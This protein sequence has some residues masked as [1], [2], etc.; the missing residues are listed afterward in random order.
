M[1]TEKEDNKI[2][3]QSF[4]CIM[5]TSC[6]LDSFYFHCSFHLSIPHLLVICLCTKKKKNAA[7]NSELTKLQYVEVFY[8]PLL[9]NA[10]RPV[11]TE[12]LFIGAPHQHPTHTA[13][14]DWQPGTVNH[15]LKVGVFI[16]A[17]LEKLKKKKSSVKLQKQIA[18]C[19]YQL[20]RLTDIK[21]VRIFS[22]IIV[23]VSIMVVKYES[24]GY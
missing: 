17:H 23:P 15:F 14:Y 22:L 16:S 8:F 9:T 18:F 19:I 21:Q 4:R 12:P 6:F 7:E 3:L 2:E 10:T 11:K 1:S 24:T 20:C 13:F 5:N